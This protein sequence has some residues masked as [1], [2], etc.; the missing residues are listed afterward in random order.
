MP[1]PYEAKAVANFFLKK[2]HLTQMKLHKLV[3]YSQGWHL[4]L[5]NAPLLSEMIQAWQFG[6]VV[7]S[8]Y[9]EFKEFGVEP[10]DRLAT[11][12]NRVPEIDLYDRFVRGLLE[13]IWKV[14]GVYTA[15]RLSIMTH[16][17]GSPWSVTD[18]RNPGVRNVDIPNELIAAHFRRLRERNRQ[19]RMAIYDK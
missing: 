17:R 12:F 1:A 6:P 3:Y 18:H 5:R 9:H 8:L 2:Q 19:R 11:Q 13:K 15:T 7:P 14:Y 10:I 4:T 16:G